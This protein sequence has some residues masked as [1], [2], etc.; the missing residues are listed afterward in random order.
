ML[1]L[2]LLQVV[3]TPVNTGAAPQTTAPPTTAAAATTAAPT[4]VAA[5]APSGLPRTGSSSGPLVGYGLYRYFVYLRKREMKGAPEAPLSVVTG[6]EGKVP[7]GQAAK[8]PEKAPE[9][10]ADAKQLLKD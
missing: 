5:A 4:T 7:E 6:P 3:D 10:L 2:Q 1:D 8:K 9:A